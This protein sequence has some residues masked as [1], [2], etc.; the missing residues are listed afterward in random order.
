[1]KFT[2]EIQ[3]DGAAFDDDPTCEVARLLRQVAS[4]VEKDGEPR[5]GLVDGNGN[6]VG[7]YGFAVT[8]LRGRRKGQAARKF[9]YF[10]G[11]T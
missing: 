1:M 4:R 7:S 3:C 10:G 11:T 5:G 2:V 9:P 8:Q 6:S